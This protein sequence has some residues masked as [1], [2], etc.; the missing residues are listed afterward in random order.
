MTHLSPFRRGAAVLVSAGLLCGVLGSGVAAAA[1]P[2]AVHSPYK[3]RVTAASRLALRAGPGTNYR[4]VGSLHHGEV[5]G[6]RCKTNGRNIHG[7]PHWYK[8][9]EGRFAWAWASARYIRSIG[10]TPRW[11]REGHRR[12]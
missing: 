5:V 4:V 8:I 6:I 11:C 10:E 9:H 1:P 2:G 12:I 3:G 7:N